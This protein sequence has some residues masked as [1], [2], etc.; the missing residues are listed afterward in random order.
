MDQNN[1]F[2]K[3]QREK[4]IDFVY[5]SLL[6]TVVT[7]ICCSILFYY[8]DTMGSTQK[9]FVIAKMDRVRQFQDIQNRQISIVD[10]IYNKIGVFNP[11]VNA[12]Y[13]ENDIKYYLNDIKNIYENNSHDERYKIFNQVSNFYNM[14]FSDKKELWSK[15]Q[16][17]ANFQKNLEECQ[18]GLDRRREELNNT[19]R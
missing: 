8:T 7:F 12:S 3:N 6:F 10:S 14:W 15:H 9:E 1:K 18:I 4:I 13:E 17:I 19:R 16:N 11:G 2:T 5:V